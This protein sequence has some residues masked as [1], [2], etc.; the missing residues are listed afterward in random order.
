VAPRLRPGSTGKKGRKVTP[1]PKVLQQKIPSERLA[2]GTKKEAP[3]TDAGD[4]S[5]S[6]SPLNARRS[7]PESRAGPG[8]AS[9]RFARGR[10]IH[11]SDHDHDRAC[12]ESVSSRQ[13]SRYPGRARHGW[14]RSRRGVHRIA[15][16]QEQDVSRRSS[17][18]RQAGKGFWHRQRQSGGILCTPRSRQFRAPK[19]APRGHRLERMR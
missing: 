9:T 16:T 1:L 13:R 5:G 14:S 8:N 3:A 17:Y 2:P 18:Q 15:R 19:E 11:P 12:D 10:R 4:P 6:R 7:C